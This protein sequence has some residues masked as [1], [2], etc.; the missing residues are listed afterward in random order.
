MPS[1]TETAVGSAPPSVV[2]AAKDSHVGIWLFLLAAFYVLAIVFFDSVKNGRF[3]ISK[4]ALRHLL[5]GLTFATG[6]TIAYAIWDTSY[7]KIVASNGVYTTV[8][9]LTCILGPLINIAERYGRAIT[10]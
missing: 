9:S 5:D 4:N 6:C 1:G 8:T 3:V 10:D 7:F 2:D